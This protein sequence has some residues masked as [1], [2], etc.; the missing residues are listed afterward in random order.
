MEYAFRN[1]L[2][3]FMLVLGVLA[4]LTGVVWA[5]GTAELTG[6]V[7]D[8][9]GAVVANISVT[10]INSATADKR[11]TVT[12][13]AGIYRFVALPVVGTYTLEMSPKGFKSTKIANIVVSVGSTVTHDV[14]L[15]LGSTSEQVTV[16]AGAETVQTNESDLSQLVD[17]RTWQDMPLQV[18][19]Q[20]SFINLVAGAVPQAGSGT[21]RGAE[22]NGTRS[23]SGSYLV[24]GSDNNEQGQAGRGQISPYDEGGASTSISPDAIQEYRVITNSFSAEYGKGGGFITDTVLKGGTNNWHGSA[25]EYNRIQALTANDWF[26]N[27]A[28]PRIQDSL[29]RN[30][31]GGSIGGPIIKDKTF[32]YG[33]AELHRV[34]QS[35]PYGPVTTTTQQFLDFV[36]NGGLAAFQENDPN[37]F[38][39]LVVPFLEATPCPSGA[40]SGGAGITGSTSTLGPIANTLLHSPAQHY[41]TP[42]SNVDCTVIPG[43]S[44]CFSRDIWSGDALGLG[45]PIVQYPVPVYTSTTLNDPQ[46]FNEARWT[47]KMDHN[48]SDKDQ[49]HGVYLFQDGTYIEQ[50]TGGFNTVGPQIIQDGRGENF[51]LTWNHTFSPT[52]LNTLRL[53]YLRH[54][55]NFP[56]PPG[57]LGVPAYY[58]IDGM[59]ADFGQYS[60]LPQF[61]TENQFQYMDTMSV[62]KGKH[63]FKFGGE[64]RR[65]RNGS[66]F[67]NDA[68][69]SI[70]PWSVEG[71][72][73]DLQM[74]SIEEQVLFG[75]S[76]FGAAYLATAAVDT[77]TGN[78]PKF[79]RGYRANEFAGFVQDDW[80]ITSRLTVNLGL[81]WEYF[82]PPHNFQSNIDSNFYFGQPVTP[83]VT[84][85]T[86]A[87]FP[88]NNPFFA[89]VSTGSFQVRNNEIWNKDTNNFGP[90]V[91]FAWDVMGNQKFVVRAGAGVMYDRIYNNLFENIRF[92]PPFFSDNQI[93]I[94]INGVGAPIEALSYPFTTRSVFADPAFAPKPNPRHMDQ[95]IVTPYY[96]QVHFGAQWEF[97]K[98][99]VF[100]PEYVGTW[101]KKLTGILD[102]NTFNGRTSGNGNS[103]R[104]NSNIGADNF[105]NNGF[106][107]NYNA[108]QM[109]LRKTYSSG[110]SL[111]ANYTYAKSLDVLSDAF[112][113]KGAL[114]PIDDQ[115]IR[116]NYGPAD[117]DL[118]HRIVATIGYDL[119]FMKDNRW[120]GGWGVNS[121]ISWQSGHPFSPYSSSSGYDLNK[122]GQRTD[123]LVVTGSALLSGSAADAC[124]AAAHINGGNNGKCYLN[125][126]NWSQFNPL[127]LDSG[128]SCP[129]NVNDGFWCNAPI[130]RNTVFGPHYSNVDFNITKKFKVT[131]S[132]GLTFQ[133]N[134]FDLFNHPNFLPPQS[135]TT[136]ADIR[137]NNF[138]QLTATTG[139]TGGHRVIQLALR[140]DF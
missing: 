49:I 1:T 41:P 45:L 100:E 66:S 31:F 69:S 43:P 35:S 73:T 75:G 59:S 131:E 40:F 42:S 8:P 16:E 115:N 130:G 68:F 121:I 126:D 118:R 60:G 120:L 114:S 136:S 89:S 96:E 58:T 107:S 33:T 26:S 55:L 133:A 138:G 122:N 38:C 14:K 87:Y 63:S 29:V 37:G 64:Y 50:F 137:N 61:F 17:H 106:Y 53:G 104:P 123:R 19:N 32:F 9:S 13:P 93:G 27:H 82:G 12:T 140:F 79:Y 74:S 36:Q 11:T 132:S 99:W 3:R 105:R 86:N 78:V 48:F 76:Y 81:R 101:G 108:L 23:G 119:P 70:F 128:T 139:D 15:E 67:F 65:T 80:R 6:L 57:A 5:Q 134:F 18:R 94:F 28:N 47:M 2:T 92:N 20:N 56:S 103:T 91:G 52:V 62:V 102:I 116:Y 44:V 109:S 46:S 24:E 21:N 129:L 77:T 71:V 54:K 95:N 88:G 83:I 124:T 112:N 90:R 7:T 22:V 39:N 51:A 25:F 125:T 110:L 98:G 72:L 127:G 34:R 113:G 117:F 97:A 10:L 30:Q 111:T 84:T 135:A 85:S 4:L